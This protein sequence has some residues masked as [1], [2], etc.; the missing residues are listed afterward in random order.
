MLRVRLPAP[1]LATAHRLI[2]RRLNAPMTSS[3]GRLF[4]GVAA[5]AGVRDRVSYEG[6]AA[7][8]LEWLASAVP[9]DG[10]YTFDIQEAEGGESPLQVDTRPL[11]AEVAAEAR[12]GRD[13]AVI[14]RRFHST[15]VEIV[16][17]VCSPLRGRTGL[18][19]V[20]L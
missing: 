13:A 11:I 17:R 20:A 19:A 7:M 15:L 16:A 1:A 14:G 9:A 18:A 12:R 3:A 4:D 8:E 2:D 6:Q 10:T 5:L